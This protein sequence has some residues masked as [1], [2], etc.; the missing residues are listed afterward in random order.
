MSVRVLPTRI[1]P[2]RTIPTGGS[3]S[4]GT[5]AALANMQA[6]STVV[7]CRPDDLTS[8]DAYLWSRAESGQVY[9]AFRFTGTQVRHFVTRGTTNFNFLV[10]YAALPALKVGEFVV[11]AHTWNTN[12]TAAD[13]RLFAGTQHG[14][15]TEAR[16]YNTRTVGAGALADDSALTFR[17]WAR[18]G[19]SNGL[20]GVGHG[21]WIKRDYIASLAELQEVADAMLGGLPLDLHD[22]TGA[23]YTGLN[24][25]GTVYDYSH[26]LNHGTLSTTT[27]GAAPRLR[28]VPRRIVRTA[29]A[30]GSS[31]L[32]A[33]P[34]GVASTAALGTP[35]VAFGLGVAPAGVSSTAS[36]GTPVSAFGLG[37]SPAG[38]A[39]AAA[40]GTAVVTMGLSAAPAGVSS[41]AAVGTP[42]VAMGAGIAPTGVASAA[43]LGTPAVSFGG[44][45]AAS[46]TGVESVAA[47]GTPAVAFG[48][49]ASPAGVSSTAALGT[50]V[51]AMGLGIAPTGVAS[52]A[53][54]GT[55][56]VAF[57][58]NL[59]ASPTGVSSTASLGT[60]VVSF[61]CVILPT[62]VSA[63][64]ALGIPVVTMGMLAAIVGVESA[65]ALGTPD[66]AFT[67]PST[68][69]LYIAT[70]GK[71]RLAGRPYRVTMTAVPYDAPLSGRPYRTELTE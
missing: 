19:S 39:S 58:G 38:V 50:P 36:L 63:S 64:A 60:P 55:P 12:G 68:V 65:A 2:G 10:D 11:I 6:G 47:I 53:A 25:S 67:D 41:T 45:L 54:L 13:Q 20:N 21:I 32:S 44:A 26:N 5:A 49:A 40:L 34:T 61:S 43:A 22:P 14:R 15:L 9:N 66:V 46:P 4:H 35:V 29:P 7:V 8:T 27:D 31:D 59:S 16:A 1:I 28:W 18:G 56:A 30:G 52:T 51:V 33:S 48:L 62:G 23:W 24:G 70:R 69:A 42:V 37:A 17:Q 57:G 71:V 3:C